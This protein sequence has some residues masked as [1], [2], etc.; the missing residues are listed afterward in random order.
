[1]GPVDDSRGFWQR[2]GGKVAGAVAGAGV[3]LL[4]KW[5]GF[6]WALLVVVLAFLGM[7]LGARVSF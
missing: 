3:A 5:L 7:Q 6:G 4:I 1:M 2:N